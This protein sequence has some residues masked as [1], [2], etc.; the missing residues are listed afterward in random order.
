MGCIEHWVVRGRKREIGIWIP[1]SGIMVTG[2]NY[3]APRHDA[4]SFASVCRKPIGPR[5]I[6]ILGRG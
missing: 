2:C 3:I 6:I 1:E 5:R 4:C